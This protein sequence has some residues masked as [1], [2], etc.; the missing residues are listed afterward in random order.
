VCSCRERARKRYADDPAHRQKRISDACTYKKKNKEKINEQ[1]RRRWQTDSAYR[2][3]RLAAVRKHRESRRDAL[4]EL[5]RLRYQTDPAHREKV[6]A[7]AKQYRSTRGLR[8]RAPYDPQ[9]HRNRRLISVYGISQEEYDAML[10]RQGG[11]CAICKKKPDEGKVL[12][13]DHCHVTGMVR[14]LL[15]KKCNSLL[16]FGNDDPDILR[17]AIAYLQA[18]AARDRDR[19]VTGRDT[20]GASA[21][22]MRP[23]DIVAAETKPYDS[24]VT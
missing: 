7:R 4:N 23:A 15:C 20:A 9:Y 8:P 1:A 2:A 10:T 5:R 12:F 18:A 14:G 16:A 24:G 11:V 13:V 6:L 19:N 3:R 22:A 17:A 21:R